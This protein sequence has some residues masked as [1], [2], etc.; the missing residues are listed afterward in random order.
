MQKEKEA[1]IAP[2]GWYKGKGSAQKLQSIGSRMPR[3]RNKA[4]GKVDTCGSICK[5][6]GI[7][8]PSP[9]SLRK[10]KKEEGK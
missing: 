10:K 7:S 4:R 1:E 9:E 2:S 8:L 6:K 3:T 5:R